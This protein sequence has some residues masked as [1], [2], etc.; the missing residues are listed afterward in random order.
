[1]T[2]GNKSKC[3]FRGIGLERECQLKSS[4]SEV[5]I[6]MEMVLPVRWLVLLEGDVRSEWGY[7]HEKGVGLVGDIVQTVK[8]EGSDSLA[9]AIGMWKQK[10]PTP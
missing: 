5:G 1:M 6:E 8:P 3:L 4:A 2:L 10:I 7:G 9:C